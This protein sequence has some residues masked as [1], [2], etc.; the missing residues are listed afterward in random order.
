LLVTPTYVLTGTVRDELSG[1][2]LSAT[3][4]VVGSPIPPVYTDPATGQ[5]S[6]ALMQGAYTLKAEHPY[7][8]SQTVTVDLQANQQQDFALAA[9][10]MLVA[11]DDQAYGSYYTSSLDRLGYDYMYVTQ[12]PDLSALTYFQG[13]V[14]LTGDQVT[15]T[16]TQSDQAALAA[17]L[18]GG[19]RLF[20]SGQN[21][22]QD[23]GGSSFFGDYLHASFT[24][25]DAGLYV[26][27][28]QEYLDPLVDIV[29]QGGQ[30]AANQTSPDVITPANSGEAVY[31]YWTY[32]L[33]E[34]AQYG[35]VAYS[36]VYRTVYFSFGFEGINRSADRD[37]VM[38]TTLG[39][40]GLCTPPEAPQAG[41]TTW[42]GDGRL[43]FHFT[44]TTQ[45]TPLMSYQ[46]DFGDGSP[47]SSQANPDHVYAQ[48]GFY[49]VTLTVT[50]RYGQDTASSVV[51]APYEVYLP[52]MGK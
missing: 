13:V 44:N 45:G 50:S 18:D 32:P 19:G 14:W 5:Y 12:S 7:H 52:N 9:I 23:I 31:R 3:V 34:P 28:G 8:H 37:Q 11:G 21:I 6:I 25:P 51:Y 1:E 48:P 38:D 42:P 10:C 43:G 39:Y 41:F 24:A 15:S 33:P 2:P 40:L 17:Y 4:S 46:W 20:V 30:G 22:G 49:I 26:L 29:I 27:H 36:G 47:A 35:G 16:L